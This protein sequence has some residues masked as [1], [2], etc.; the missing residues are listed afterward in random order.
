VICPHF[1]VLS[2]ANGCLY[3]CAY[4][5]LKYTMRN[6]LLEEQQKPAPA[7]F[8]NTGEMR[9][10]LVK[11]ASETH[12][13]ALINTGELSDSFLD[14]AY[15]DMIFKTLAFDRNFR[16][17]HTMLFVTKGGENVV[18]ALQPYPALKNFIVSFSVSTN[19]ALYEMDAPHVLERLEAARVLRERGW[20]I[21]LRLD[22]LVP[23]DLGGSVD[24]KHIIEMCVKADPERVTL[25]SLRFAFRWKFNPMLRKA[26]SES[27]HCGYNGKAFKMRVPL[28]KRIEMYEKVITALR[29]CGY[30]EWVGF[31][32][33]TTA[34]FEHFD[35]DVNRPICNCSL[36]GD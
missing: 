12:E 32:K 31:C 10:Q 20:R 27:D 29:T 22:P 18:E 25:G 5:Y 21:R 23:E 3:N 14:T 24:P 7:V 19:A 17:R 8:T 30:K 16:Q 26:T 35:L 33:E 4:C 11:W 6:T 1:Y 15:L 36:F 28:S 2:H 34:I 9:E 13:P